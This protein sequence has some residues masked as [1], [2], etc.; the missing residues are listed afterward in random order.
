MTASTAQPNDAD[1]D[2]SVPAADPPGR[3]T[4]AAVKRWTWRHHLGIA[5]IDH[6]VKNVFMLPG[7]ALALLFVDAP[8]GT[9]LW[10]SLIAVASLC[11]CASAN[12]TINEFVDGEFDRFH[13]LK[14]IRPA[15]LGLL[16]GRL[17]AL[18]YVCLAASGL[19][20]ALVIGRDFAI[21]NVLLLVMGVIYN[22]RPIR[23]KDRPYLDVLSE[24]LNNPLRL[25]LGWFVVVDS[26][27]PPSSILASYWLGGAF[28]MAVKRFNEL[29]SIA[30]PAAAG[31]YRLSF[32]HYNE[33]SLLLSCFF[34]AL[35]SS[36][37]LGV[38]L[39]KYRIE[40]LLAFPLFALMF[41]WYL[42]IGLRPGS[43]AQAPERLYTERAFL[44]YVGIVAL[45]MTALFFIDIPQMHVL[46]EPISV[47]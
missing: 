43:S 9:L 45:C 35:C 19:G 3:G 39:I 22:A 37:L 40:F 29:R 7:I 30:D 21:C 42:A 12:Y 15:A 41:T 18:Q 38:F 36:F 31:R 27:V 33:N 26:V 4:V 16:D 25:L 23:T 13:P 47:R 5:R 17:V 2:A 32:R 34:Y 44:A 10:R 14:S 20:T 8:I 6:W 28:L 1:P 46:V 24:A 11:L